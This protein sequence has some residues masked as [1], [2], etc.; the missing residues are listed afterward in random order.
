MD[1]KGNIYLLDRERSAINKYNTNGDFLDDTQL[2]RMPEK[3]DF[4]VS[5]DNL[6]S[7]VYSINES[8]VDIDAL[9]SYS[10][11]YKTIENNK[12]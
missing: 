7:I 6:Y 3:F 2:V 5:I 12:H 10:F 4:F 9:M 1:N 8:H 11:S